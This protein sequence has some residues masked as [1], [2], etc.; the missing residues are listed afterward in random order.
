[1]AW[2]RLTYN[3]LDGPLDPEEA[4]GGYWDPCPDCDGDHDP[5]DGCPTDA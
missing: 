4:E 1:M 3:P 5:D 2:H